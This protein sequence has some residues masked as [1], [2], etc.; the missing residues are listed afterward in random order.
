MKIR[1]RRARLA[2]VTTYL[3]GWSLAI[4]EAIDSVKD[5]ASSHPAWGS[6][7]TTM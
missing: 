1:P 5:F 7:G 2:T 3:S 6:T 4:S